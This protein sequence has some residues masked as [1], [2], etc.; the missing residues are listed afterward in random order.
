MKKDTH[1]TL[2][3]NNIEEYDDERVPKTSSLG[4]GYEHILSERVKIVMLFFI[5]G[6]VP[7]CAYEWGTHTW[8]RE[9]GVHIAVGTGAVCTLVTSSLIYIFGW[10][11]DSSE[12]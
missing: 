4:D 8:G 3:T 7:L 2:V 1:L 5:M 10:M 11:D 12:I 6:V 9:V